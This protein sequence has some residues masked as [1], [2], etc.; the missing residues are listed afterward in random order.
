MSGTQSIGP[1]QKVS[2]CGEHLIWVISIGDF[3]M[4]LTIWIATRDQIMS[5]YPNQYEERR[6][7]GDLGEL[8]IRFVKPEDAP[9]LIDLFNSLSA[10]SIYFRFF[11]PLKELSHHMLTR[12]TRI[13]YDRQIALVAIQD[14][15]HG[16]K[17]LGMARIIPS[18]D[19]RTAEFAVLVGD[20]W[21]GKGIGGELFRRCLS[22]GK[23]RKIPSVWGKV[24]YENRKMLA[25]AHKYNAKMSK[26]PICG[27][28]TVSVDCQAI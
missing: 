22:I 3:L 27:E 16:E 1:E 20:Q 17:M 24:L 12:L 2:Y 8:C 11:T 25:L 15:E 4:G 19:Q 21:Q 6:T 26:A 9:L 18:R 14:T 23:E 7:F 28:Y 13:D 10:Q 5:S